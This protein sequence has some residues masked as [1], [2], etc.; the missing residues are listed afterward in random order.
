M[1]AAAWDR[2]VTFWDLDQKKQIGSLFAHDREVSAMTLSEDGNTLATGNNRG[3]IKFWNRKADSWASV[4]LPQQA[5]AINCLRFSPQSALFASA[6]ND[7]FTKL[8]D[9]NSGEPREV[10]SFRSSTSVNAVAFSG[11]GGK[12]AFAGEDRI[13]HLCDVA[14]LEELP[15]QLSCRSSVN[16]LSFSRDGAII[17]A[18]CEDGTITLW[19]LET[20]HSSTHPGH[21]AAVLSVTLSNDGKLLVTGSEDNSIKLWPINNTDELDDL[22]VVTLLGHT[23]Y[24]NQVALTP[25]C[26][27]LISASN[28]GLIKLWDGRIFPEVLEFA[29]HTP[30]IT[31]VAFSPSSTL[32]AAD[33]GDGSVAIRKRP[34]YEVDTSV[35]EIGASAIV[36]ISDNIIAVGR[37]D[38]GVNI[39][40]IRPLERLCAFDGGDGGIVSL[41]YAP[42]RQLLAAGTDQVNGQQGCMVKVWDV[43]AQKLVAV[44]RAHDRSV[45]FVCF[46]PNG[47]VLASGSW[48]HK[49][50]FWNT[51]KL[52]HPLDDSSPSFES[53]WI[54]KGDEGFAGPATFSKDSRTLICGTWSKSI[55]FIDVAGH[56]ESRVG[57]NKSVVCCSALS[58]DGNTLATGSL[59]DRI[60]LWDL[61]NKRQLATLPTTLR[62]TW[63]VEFSPDGLSLASGGDDGILRLYDCGGTSQ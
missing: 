45:R 63:S 11:D 1:A 30:P 22:G 13:V 56:H 4:N 17:V 23:D 39:W 47:N 53:L 19:N 36:F 51:R 25:K 55:L 42:E 49:V 27:L 34:T 9:A 2:K 8:W 50:N 52:I 60:T 24:V 14:S 37:N 61:N 38:G 54:F 32:A 31:S 6:C 5:G 57:G 12:L 16:S 43:A 40:R 3:E 20:N 15:T 7:H 21:L 58:P 10:K 26:E 62:Y 28:D 59:N 33:D 18:G 29:A 35:P 41:A 48:D 46:A 44:M